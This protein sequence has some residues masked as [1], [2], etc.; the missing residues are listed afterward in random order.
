MFERAQ[1]GHVFVKMVKI[2]ET[3]PNKIYLRRQLEIFGLQRTRLEETWQFLNVFKRLSP[4][5]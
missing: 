1:S 2:V 4:C 5:M 3:V